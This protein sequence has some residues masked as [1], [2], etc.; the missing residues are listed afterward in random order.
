MGFSCWELSGGY[1]NPAPRMLQ[2]QEF[3]HL[4]GN[5]MSS[6][7]AATRSCD[8]GSAYALALRLL[9]KISVTLT[10]AGGIIQQT[11]KSLVS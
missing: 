1:P 3:S 8:P 11:C 6:H 2:L 7:D 9:C 5:L 4:A 10:A